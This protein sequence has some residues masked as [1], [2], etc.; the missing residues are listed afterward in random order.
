MASGTAP[1]EESQAGDVEADEIGARLE[2]ILEEV[3]D[4]FADA[5]RQRDEY[6]D[7]LRRLQAEFENYRK[8]VARQADEATDRATAAVLERILPALDALDLAREHAGEPVDAI[9]KQL[10]SALGQITSLLRDS[11]AREGLDRVDE[12]GVGFDPLIHD[13]V[14]HEP[15]EDGD[16]PGVVVT[17]VLRAGY[18]LKGRVVRP[19]MVKVR[20]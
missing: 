20:G 4:P 1:D 11:L 8:R 13:A 14:A 7:D 16:A 18:R 10:A 6:L 2:A 3:P 12:V 5:L 15:A 17:E 19:A 9:A